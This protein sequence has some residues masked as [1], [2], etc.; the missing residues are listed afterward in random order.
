MGAPTTKFGEIYFGHLIP[1]TSGCQ[2]EGPCEKKK[3]ARAQH[4][5]FI[6]NLFQERITALS[7]DLK[8]SFCSVAA[9]LMQ[10]GKDENKKSHE[11]ELTDNG[12]YESI[13]EDIMFVNCR[14]DMACPGLLSCLI[15]CF[16]M[17]SEKEARREREMSSNKNLNG[18]CAAAACLITFQAGH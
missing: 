12:H 17:F 15:C 2:G 7:R 11:E 16:A 13:Q 18:F 3:Q 1:K 6:V 14:H 8:A 4:D 10:A 9:D 5:V